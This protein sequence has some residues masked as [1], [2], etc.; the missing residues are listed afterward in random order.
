MGTSKQ[1]SD[2]EECIPTHSG[3]CRGKDSLQNTSSRVCVKGEQ[4]KAPDSHAAKK[5]FQQEQKRDKDGYEKQSL[6]EG[7]MERENGPI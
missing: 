2:C 6:F 3:L 5:M 4:K 1:F 7:E